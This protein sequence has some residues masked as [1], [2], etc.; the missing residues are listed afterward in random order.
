[1]ASSVTVRKAKSQAGLN[2]FLRFPWQH[3]KDDPHWVPPLVGMQRAKLDK[4]KN[5]AWEY[6]EGDYF[7]A[8][9]GDQPVGTIA[10]FINHRHNEFHHENI[11][12]FGFFECIDDQAVADA[13]LGTAADTVRALGCDAIRGPANFSTND[14]CGVLIKGFDDPPVILMPYNYRYYQRLLANAPGYAKVMDVISYN[15]TLTQWQASPKLEQT[16]RVTRRNNERRGITVR[17]IDARNL[18]RDLA[19]FKAIYNQAWDENWGF[20]PLS[21][22]ELDALVRDL[23]AYL[24]PRL[25]IFAAVH[26]EPA[27]FLL[28]FP[29]LNQPLKAAYPRPGKPSL[30]T[31]AQVFWHWKIRSKVRRIRVALFGVKEQFRGTG[32]EAAM[33]VE[34]FEQAR[35]IS[36]E[37]GWYYA[38]CGWV[39]ET[40][41][42]MKRLVTAY[43]GDDYK[44]Y[45][46][47]ER[48]LTP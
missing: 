27:A 25:A 10:A 43:G 41:E 31:L 42:T 34:L 3:Y 39:L 47:Y 8:W 36:A 22:K 21:D 30:I 4:R 2:T 6:M 29:D 9:R 18:K 17:T 20:V 7:I 32:V 33:F 15:V 46:F 26:G 23:G 13:L 37:T 48:Q 11:G 5:P 35:Q 44:H 12:F 40:N 1:M 19:L 14:E 16:M 24:E 28:A 45:R 38:D